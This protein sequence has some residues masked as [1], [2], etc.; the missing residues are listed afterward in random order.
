MFV[1]FFLGDVL[2][3][4]RFHIP[5]NGKFGKSSTQKCHFG[6]GYVSSQEGIG[7][8]SE[9]LKNQVTFDVRWIIRYQRFCSIAYLS[10]LREK[11]GRLG[12]NGDSATHLYVLCI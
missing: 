11:T 4:E 6:R 1:C 7:H 10:H 2:S 5:P 12:C 9:P 3:R 8:T